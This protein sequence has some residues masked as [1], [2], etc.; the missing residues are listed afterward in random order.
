MPAFFCPAPLRPHDTVHIIAPAGA[1]PQ[2]AFA[3]GL[4]VLSAVK[5]QVRWDPALLTRSRY[6]AGSVA[7]RQ[8]ELGAALRDPGTRAIWAARGGYGTGQLL[9]GLDSEAI[10]RHDKW[11]VGFSDLTGLHGRW[12]QAQ[13][14]S[15]HGANI[16]TLPNWTPDARTELFAL[17]GMGDAL[18]MPRYYAATLGGGR[19]DAAAAGPYTGRLWGGNLTVLASLVGSGQLPSADALGPGSI[20]LLEEV[21]E[22]P[23]RLDRCWRQLVAAGVTAGVAAVAVG[24]LTH[25]E[26]RGADYTA[27]EMLLAAIAD[28]GLPWLAGLPMGHADDARAVVFG[29]RAT[30]DIAAAQL[31]V[32]P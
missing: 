14:C 20:L 3:A 6:F 25:C 21:G 8:A 9:A 19:P 30:V 31:T 5:L 13:R 27:H 26:A 28:S 11:L 22:A 2:A 16:T 1:V 12:Q 4:E 10:G 23:Y 17:L 18:P 29:A 7:R 32:W 24:Q 15:I